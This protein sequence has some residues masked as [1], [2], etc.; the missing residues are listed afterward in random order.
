MVVPSFGEGWGVAWGDGEAVV[1][2]LVLGGLGWYDT[3]P[4]AREIGK[5]LPQQV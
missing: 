1:G 4:L 2:I 3:I 5:P